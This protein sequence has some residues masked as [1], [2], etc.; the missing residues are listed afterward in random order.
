[1]KRI[2]K[3]LKNYSLIDM[4]GVGLLVAILSV[5]MFFF[6][7]KAS[8]VTIDL[9]VTQSD[10]LAEK[11]ELPLWYLENLKPGMVQND[12]FGRTTIKIEDVFSY[13]TGTTK[14]LY[15][16]KLKLRSVYDG[17]TGVYSY[18]GSPIMLGSY[19]TFKV[20]QV[21]IRGVVQGFGEN[22]IREHKMVTIEGLAAPDGGDAAN[23]I[24]D[25]I[26]NYISEMI[27]DGLQMKDSRGNVIATV[28]N[29]KKKSATREFIYQDRLIKV[30]DNS[31]TVVS[32]DVE[33]ELEKYGDL[34]LFRKDYNPAVG[35]VFYLDFVDFAVP[36]VVLGTH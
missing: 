34:Y 20:G 12:V 10:I 18:D 11:E 25:G 27:K 29:V 32:M 17:K 21:V 36:V 2:Y 22:E 14:R 30:P 35:T 1:M 13:R 19:Q 15:I 8:Y 3:F 24:T 26:Q 9:R 23:T 31:R 28:K 33:M 5:A 6:L 7:R 4:V 16:V